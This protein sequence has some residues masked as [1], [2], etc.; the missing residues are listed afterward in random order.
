MSGLSAQ[1]FP[2]FF[3]I[4]HLHED[5]DAGIGNHLLRSL[6]VSFKDARIIL[7]GHNGGDAQPAPLSEDNLKSGS[8]NGRILVHDAE[9]RPYAYGICGQRLQHIGGITFDTRPKTHG[10]GIANGGKTDFSE[11]LKF[12]GSL[13]QR[14]QENNQNPALHDKI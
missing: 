3:G 9:V 14:R 2:G 13:F 10:A 8:D 4:L 7:T 12:G 11:A 1:Q 6:L 5:F